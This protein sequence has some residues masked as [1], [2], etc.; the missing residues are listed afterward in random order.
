[1]AAIVLTVLASVAVGV[2]VERRAHARALQL[3]RLLV[4]T[5]LWLLVPFVAY[6]NVARAHLSLDAVLSI[7]LA[8]AAIVVAGA[9]MWRLARGPLA[10]P[11][12]SLGAAIVCTI[13]A[14]TAYLGLPLCATLFSHAALRQAVA[15][16]G[17]VSLP[18]F[19]VG[20]FAVGARF[21][22]AGGQ[23]LR[24][25]FVTGVLRNP[26]LLAV[27]S[28]L[29][30]PDAW[31]P[32]FLETPSRVAVYALLPISF[33]LVGVALGEEAEEGTLAVPPPFTRPVAVVIALR[34]GFVLSVL[35]LA[36]AV[37]LDVPA[38]FYVLAATPVGTN[39]IIVAH[40]TG[41]DVRLTATSIAWTTSVALTVIVG[42]MLAGVV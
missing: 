38:P 9:I 24:A 32:A 7:A 10:L 35:L 11:R 31:A 17:I 15:Y 28:G 6:V 41:L 8:G 20:S 30:V 19:A 3:R 1:M 13:Q 26:V 16:D 21:G 33:F 5:I 40:A 42:L 39:T 12:P 36:G 37:A 14:N 27:A 2:A 18:V 29:L 22:H 23:G 34:M 4:W 25:Q